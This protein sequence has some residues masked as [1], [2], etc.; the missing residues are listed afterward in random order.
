MPVMARPTMVLHGLGA[1]EGVDGLHVHHVPHD[2]VVE[3]DAVAA[4]HVPRLGGYHAGLAG[5]VHLGQPG[6]G[7]GQPAGFGQAADLQA[8]QLH[9]GQVRQHRYQPLLDDLEADQ[10]LAELAPLLR[11]PQGSFVGGG[12]VAERPPGAGA[13]GGGQDPGGVLKR[14]RPGQPVRHPYI[15]QGDLGL[16]DRAERHL[17]PR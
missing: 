6:H 14:A 12:G 5:V 17:P 2:L 3:Q 16:P 8:V 11:V 1:L 4:E 15:L 13:P 9:R 7:G 10:R